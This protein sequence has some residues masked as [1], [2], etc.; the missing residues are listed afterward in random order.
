[1]VVYGL[2]EGWCRLQEFE[3]SWVR[4]YLWLS[5]VYGIC[6]GWKAGVKAA[7]VDVSW[8]RGH[9]WLPSCCDG[10]CTK[11]GR[12]K[13]FVLD[14]LYPLYNTVLLP[15]FSDA[16]NYFYFFIIKEE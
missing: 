5:N 8:V 10:R 14:V 12:M 9:I 16:I 13:W 1:M 3:V 4:G 6:E 7:G 2:C 15:L 11:R